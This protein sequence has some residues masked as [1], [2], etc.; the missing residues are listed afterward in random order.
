LLHRDQIG[1]GI[2]D[3]AL[4]RSALSDR[5]EAEANRIAAD[6][7]M[8]QPLVDEWLDRSDLLGVD[9]KLTYLR[10][11]FEVSEAAMRI[12]LGLS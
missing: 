7:L 12:R 9:D 6:I 10:E 11:H 5:R 1:S 4:Y 3:D 8:P 2:T